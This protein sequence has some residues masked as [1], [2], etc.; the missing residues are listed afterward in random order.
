MN[1]SANIQKIFCAAGSLMGWFAVIEQLILMLLNQQTPLATTLIQFISY[2]TI[3]TN[4]LVALY[5]TLLWL[6]PSSRWG[7]FFSKANN[8]TAVAVYITIVGLVY[9]IILR[10]LWKPEGMQKLVDE[11]LHTVIPLYFILYWVLF[12]PKNSLGWKNVFNWLLY[13][14]VYLI[15]ILIRGSVTG[16]YPYPFIDVSIIGFSQ[17]LTNCRLV[18]I[19]FLVISF[20]FIG[21][22]RVL[23]KPLL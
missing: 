11:L 18:F 14:F 13:P 12:V 23:K 2:F 1:P 5:F 22:A 7:Q 3:L 21:L 10:S 6:R 17:A 16:L 8:S 9:N 20:L 4:I 19:A 15:Y